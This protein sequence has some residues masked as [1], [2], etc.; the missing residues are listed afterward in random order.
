MLNKFARDIYAKYGFGMPDPDVNHK[1][2]AEIFMWGCGSCGNYSFITPNNKPD[3][4]G[5]I[6][7]ALHTL[8]LYI[9]IDQNV[10]FRDVEAI[11]TAFVLI[12]S[13]LGQ[14]LSDMFPENVRFAKD[15]PGTQLELLKKFTLTAGKVLVEFLKEKGTEEKDKF[16][17][18]MF[19]IFGMV[20]EELSDELSDPEPA[21]LTQATAHPVEHP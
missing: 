19:M 18:S 21:P 9:T 3:L 2:L 16:I 12:R 6:S 17:H 7:Q 1:E 5:M 13:M 14:R 20:P 8:A 15:I 4:Q 10:Y 11:L